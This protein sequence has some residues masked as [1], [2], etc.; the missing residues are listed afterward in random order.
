MSIFGFKKYKTD[1]SKL[2]LRVDELHRRILLFA[3]L[4]NKIERL[5]TGL[6]EKA[7][8]L[9]NRIMTIDRKSKYTI[10]AES[11]GSLTKGEV[12]S[13]G[14]AGRE[15]N[16]GYVAMY[17]SRITAISVS[18]DRKA[19]EVNIGILINGKEQFP[20]HDI[21][22]PE[23]IGSRMERFDQYPPEVL[24][25]ETINFVSKN[26]NPTNINTVACLML[27]IE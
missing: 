13:F 21:K 24:A 14:N 20:R 15:P 17:K 9:E 1:E 4:D 11:K 6:A 16:V 25:G 22:L 18:S 3:G 2:T 7:E 8:Y 19:G 26:N 5:T 12:F 10:C 23:K 27:E